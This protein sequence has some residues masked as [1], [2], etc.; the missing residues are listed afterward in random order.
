MSGQDND[1]PQILVDGVPLVSQ[2]VLVTPQD[3]PLHQLQQMGFDTEACQAAL[4]ACQSEGISVDKMLET[5]INW[6]MQQQGVNPGDARAITCMF[7]PTL[8]GR[9]N[10]VLLASF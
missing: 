3:D 8:D 5:C 7:S 10:P 6:L 2:K 1:S 9:I 4:A